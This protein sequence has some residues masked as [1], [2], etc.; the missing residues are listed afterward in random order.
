MRSAKNSSVALGL[1]S[2]QGATPWP[3]T[4]QTVMKTLRGWNDALETMGIGTTTQAQPR[5]LLKFTRED[6]DDCGA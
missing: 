3:P 1:V 5:G 2:R 4:H 6:Y